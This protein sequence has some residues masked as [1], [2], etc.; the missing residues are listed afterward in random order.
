MVYCKRS[1][2]S[3]FEFIFR[4]IKICFILPGGNVLLIPVVL[5]FLVNFKESNFDQRNFFTDGINVVNF[6]SFLQ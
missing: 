1:I 5:F 4:G 3:L 6:N 2:K